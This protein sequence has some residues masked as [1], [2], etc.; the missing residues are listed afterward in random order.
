MKPEIIAETPC[1]G[2]RFLELLELTYAD[3]RGRR[4]TWESCRRRHSRG[5]VVILAILE[6]EQQVVLIRQ[7]R[8]PVGG[9]V[10]EFPAGLIDADEA[11]AEAA[12]RELLEETGY[13]GEVVALAAPVC[14]SPGMSAE[15]LYPVR[16]RVDGRAPENNPPRPRPEDGEEIE[17]ILVPLASLDAFLADRHRAGDAID[18]K[19]AF[20]AA[21]LA[22][23]ER[24]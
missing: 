16:L 21:G 14:S 1:A 22:I 7:F 17:T 3:G 5:A 24:G 15:T 9:C 11:A 12:R 23:Q 2:G 18:A 10:I 4:R 6:P 19:L 8:P 20:W 13:H